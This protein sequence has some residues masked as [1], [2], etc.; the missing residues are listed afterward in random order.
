MENKNMLAQQIQID[1][2]VCKELI[3][4]NKARAEELQAE[5]NPNYS[6]G[7]Y[8]GQQ[9]AYEQ[10]LYMLETLLEEV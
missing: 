6:N 2:A 9:L 7:C 5:Y 1:I 3:N 8:F 10:A 4:V